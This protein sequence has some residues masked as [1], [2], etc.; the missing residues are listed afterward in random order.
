MEGWPPPEAHEE[1]GV[2]KTRL[3]ESKPAVAEPAVGK[4]FDF[5][6]RAGLAI[7]G[8]RYLGRS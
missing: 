1:L 3:I 7:R 5:P 8:L 4:S 2:Q 6:G